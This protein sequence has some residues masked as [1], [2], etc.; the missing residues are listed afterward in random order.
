MDLCRETMWNT[1]NDDIQYTKLKKVDRIYDFLAE[2]N[3]KLDIVYGCILGQRPLPSLMELCFEVFFEEDC[4]NVMCKLTTPAT[5]S[6]A[7]SV[8]SSTHDNDKN[9]GKPIP[10]CEHYKKQW[11][12]KDQY[13]KLHSHPLGGKKRSF[14]KKQNSGCA[15]VSETT[16]ISTSQQTESTASQTKTPIL[17]A[18]TQPGYELGRMIV[19]AWHSGGLYILDED[20]FSS[21]ISRASLLSSYFGTSEHDCKTSSFLFFTTI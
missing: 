7:F 5:D 18:I 4:T 2:L 13:W 6:T 9:N 12:T 17:G 10:V 3:P 19:T 8:Q 15:H 20:N 11:H 16:T 1:P 14:N 21:S